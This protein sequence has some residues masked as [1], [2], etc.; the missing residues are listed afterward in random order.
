V[1][2]PSFVISMV[3][4]VLNISVR[5]RESRYHSLALSSELF[6]EAEKLLQQTSKR[7]CRMGVGRRHL[8]KL[9]RWNRENS[10]VSWTPYESPVEVLLLHTYLIE[11]GA[12]KT[13][14]AYEPILRHCL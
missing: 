12:G 10:V 1:K 8:Q 6:Y 2:D 4:Q 5:P 7:N 11:A 13:I 9:A 3:M 14:F